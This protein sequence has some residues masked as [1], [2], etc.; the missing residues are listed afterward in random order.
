[1]CVYLC[2]LFH[3]LCLVQAL[4]LLNTEYAQALRY[5]QAARAEHAEPGEVT[6]PVGEFSKRLALC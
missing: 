6:F 5:L 1:M 2:C 4:Q 3:Q